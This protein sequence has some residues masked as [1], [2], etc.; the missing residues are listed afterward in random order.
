MIGTK[1]KRN[2][3]KRTP[4][5]NNDESSENEYDMEDPF[6]AGSSSEF[7]F[8]SVSEDDTNEEWSEVEEET[9]RLVKEAKRFTKRKK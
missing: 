8:D 2:T 5:A 4:S 9:K 3:K 6:M 7:E 1:D